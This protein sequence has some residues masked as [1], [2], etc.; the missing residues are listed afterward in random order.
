M[1]TYL[2][3]L[4]KVMTKG[5]VKKDRTNTG[6][7]SY[8]GTQSRY[9]LREGF[10]LL[11]TKKMAWK[12]ICHELLWFLKGDTNI[13]YLV[14]HN[15][16][17][18][19]EWPYEAFK[20]SNDFKGESLQDFVEKI[21]TDNQFA[22]QYGK[23]GPVY[24]KQ[25][26][27]FNGVDQIEWVIN[28][29]KTNPFSRRLIVSAWNPGEIKE[30]ALPPCHSFFQFFVNEKYEISLQLYQRSGDLF[31][32]VPFNIASYSLLLLM[33]AQVTGLKP[34]E[35][36]HTIGDTHIYSNHLEQVKIQ[37][38]RE[39]KKLPKVTL[40]PDIKNIFDF[41][42]EDI[43]LENYEHHDPIKGKVAV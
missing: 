23:L 1:K 3:L 15:V 21:K 7:I 35:F 12:A 39:P 25:W 24:G 32:G 42:F 10:P 13:K 27:D 2:D 19:N 4:E 31:L 20:K 5:E 17:I 34:A 33:V 28:E 37:L 11:T 22:Q 26:R 16:N 30:M 36:I 41:R 6:T 29:I 9:D 18:W 40:N 43:S 14:D 8:F 38:Q